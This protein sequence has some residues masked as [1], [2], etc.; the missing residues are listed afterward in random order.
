VC[1]E[2]K[3]LNIKIMNNKL[4]KNLKLARVNLKDEL[5]NRAGSY[6]L[7][8]L[9]NGKTYV[10]TSKN[11]YKRLCQYT[12]LARLKRLKR[13]KISLAILKYGLENFGIRI[14]EVLNLDSVSTVTEQ[15]D[16]IVKNEQ[17][18]IDEI[19]PE[20]NLSP[21][22]GSPLGVKNSEETK[23]KKS[24]AQLNRTSNRKG[25]EITYE[26]LSNYVETHGRARPIY[27]CN[28]NNEILA[29]FPSIS[30]AS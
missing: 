16:L 9:V 14:L 21:T 13:S 17:Y 19:K 11:L 18:Y 30:I 22:A 24:L 12:E 20:Y 4:H 15:R 23:K 5:N 6:Q 2:I 27:M 25:K 1:H 29:R 8:N 28:E 10:G 26:Y 3:N 7:V